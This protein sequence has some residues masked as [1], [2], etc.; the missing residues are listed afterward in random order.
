MLLGNPLKPLIRGWISFIVAASNRQA[1]GLRREHV[2]LIGALA[3]IA[4]HKGLAVKL[5][6]AVSWHI[7]AFN[8]S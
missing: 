8:R 1:T 2:D 4:L 5:A 6:L 3:H 7:G